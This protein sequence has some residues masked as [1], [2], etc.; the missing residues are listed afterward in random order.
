MDIVFQAA[1]KASFQQLKAVLT[2]ELIFRNLD[3]SLPF[4]VQTDASDTDHGVVALVS[5]CR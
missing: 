4:L 1:V 5:V 2:S 3:F